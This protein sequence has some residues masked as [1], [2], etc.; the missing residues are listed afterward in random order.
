MFARRNYAK[1]KAE[2]V[3]HKPLGRKHVKVFVGNL[4]FGTDAERLREAFHEF[5]LI[6]DTKV[7]FCCHFTCFRF[8]F[9]TNF[10][11]G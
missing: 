4:W 1:K 2:E 11:A 5:G 3:V 7:R 6:V 8:C 10:R 9:R